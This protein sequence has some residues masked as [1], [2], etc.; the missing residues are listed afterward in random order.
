LLKKEGGMPRHK[1]KGVIDGDTFQL[2][3]GEYV[4]KVGL[5]TLESHQKGGLAPKRR[6]Q[7]K[8]YKIYEERR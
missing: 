7:S 6:L 3:D 4:Q 5:D 8:R 1:V 2:K